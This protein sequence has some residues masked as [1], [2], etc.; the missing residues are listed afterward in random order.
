MARRRAA[1]LFEKVLSYIHDEINVL[2]EGQALPT[3]LALAAKY[4]V[5]RKTVRAAMGHIEKQGLVHR[6]RGKGTF[7]TKGKQAGALFRAQLGEIGAISWCG[8]DE[9]GFYSPII[10]GAVQEAMQ[11]HRRVVLSSGATSD[12]KREACYQLI[13]DHRLEGL[14]LIAV[15]DQQLLDD[16]A[17]RSKPIVLV[18]HFAERAKID[19]VRVDSAGG[20]RLAVEHL[21]KL[22]HKRIA[23]LNN[24]HPEVNPARLRG[25]REGMKQCGLESNDDWVVEAG[26]LKGGGDAAMRLLSLPMKERPTAILSFSDDMALGA[27]QAILRFGLKVPEEMSV[28]GTGGVKQPVTVGLPELT[29]VR[30][31]SSELGR[32][33]V[34]YLLERIEKPS[35]KPR[36][37]MIPGELHWGQSTGQAQ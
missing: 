33:A 5:S 18:D 31:D 30:F 12:S 1:P 27:I 25:Y 37:V 4:G 26:G 9:G 28:V 6:V 11:H 13:D 21:H 14:L 23:F 36:N 10:E 34:K 2:E 22:G 24:L 8:V 20:S 16:L 32:T 19:C 15:T 7:P 29:C 35:L 3:E 17:K